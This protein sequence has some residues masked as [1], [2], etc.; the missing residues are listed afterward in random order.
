MKA[1]TRSALGLILLCCLV[2]L[3]WAADSPLTEGKFGQALNFGKGFTQASFEPG[4]AFS[5]LPVTIECWVKLTQKTSYNIVLAQAP[6]S[7]LHWEIYTRPGDGAVA[8]YIPRNGTVEQVSQTLIADS[9]WHFLALRLETRRASLYVDGKLTVDMP[10]VVDTYFGS[11]PVMIGALDDY[12]LRSSGA[13]DELKL[14]RGSFPLEGYVPTGPAEADAGTLFLFSFDALEEGAIPE[15][16]GKTK[17]LIRNPMS[18]PVGTVFLDE[19]QDAAYQASALFGDAWVEAESKLS[20]I[21]LECS[22]CAAPKAFYTPDRLSLEGKWLMQAA[23]AR[24]TADELKG[25]NPRES[26]GVVK[27]WFDPRTDR[28]TWVKAEVPTSVQSALIKAGLLADPLWYDNTYKELEEFGTPK[29]LPWVNRKTRIEQQEWWFAREFELPVSWQGKRTR[30]YF[31]G[32]DYSGSVYLNGKPLGYQEGMFGGPSFDVTRLLEPGDSN[33]VVVRLDKVPQ[34]W[35]GHLKGSPGWGWHYGHLIS[36]GIWREV[37]LEAVPEVEVQSPAV[38]TL[39]LDGRDA[40]LECEF[41]L[42]NLT[43]VEKQLEVVFTF[44]PANFEGAGQSFSCQVKAWPGRHRYATSFRLADAQL[45]WPVNYGEQNLYNLQMTGLEAGQATCGATTRF[46]VRTLE[47][48][49]MLGSQARVDYRW[50]FVVNGVPLFI[51]GANWCWFDVMLEQDPAKYERILELAKRGGIQMF[52]AWGGGIT[53]SDIFYDKCD[54][55]GLLVYQE[56]PYCWMPP[57]FPL[58]RGEV[59]D[60][61]VS[62]VVKRLRNHPSLLMWGGG[63]ENVAPTGADEGLFL[64]GKRCRE[65][66][67]TRPYHRTDPWGGSIHNWNVFHGGAPIDAG[68]SATPSVFFGEYGL[69]S[70]PNQLSQKRFL[71]EEALAH[72]PP[73]AEDKGIIAHLNQFDL[74]DLVKVLRY[75]DYGPVK[76]WAD[77]TEQSQLAQGDGLRFAAELQRRYSYQNKSGFWFYKF[78]DLFPGHS[79]AVLDY[80]GNPKLSYYRAKQTCKPQSAFA[81]YEKFD[82]RGDESFRFELSLGNDTS[83]PLA[84]AKVK[85]TLFGSDLAPFWNQEFSPEPV[86]AASCALL[87]EFDV[88]LPKGKSEP[89]LLG[90]RLE[91]AEG[92]LLSDQWYWLNFAHDTEPILKYENVGPYDYPATDVPDAFAAYAEDRPAPLMSLP[93]TE[94]AVSRE[95]TM[96]KGEFVITNGGELPA[97]NVQV[98]EF[99]GGFEDFLGDNSFCLWPGETRRVSYELGEGA[100]LAGLTIGAWNADAVVVQ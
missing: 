61:Q 26:E 13:F 83:Q 34:T 50:Q 27:R 92:K 7:E 97:F 84:G 56:F 49:P 20:V 30:L 18:P 16:S 93:R 66:D 12:S 98:S 38:R 95:G 53:E 46:G 65:Y 10:S 59:L 73:T 82:W 32:I 47:M 14:S 96:R 42:E 74:R 4:E 64:V 100:S 3:A 22:P 37:R 79:W 81:S 88:L 43:G 39:K 19:V 28:T 77:Y 54:E 9:A 57:D 6:K 8:L 36:T 70:M 89:F 44:E 72:W 99:P 33:E 45:W 15:A 11:A 5:E 1:G 51:K 69:P 90:V 31:D 68:Y 85:A 40:D 75:C 35:F 55:K 63:N 62:R 60:Q 29:E 80:Y 87:G 76:D 67:P 41:Y 2:G 21:R 94:L 48:R 91:G 23:G 71:P 17:A 78:T 24:A 52:R 25:L 58:T 86:A